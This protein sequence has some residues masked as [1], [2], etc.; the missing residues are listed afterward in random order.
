MDS[1]PKLVV[2]C[3]DMWCGKESGT[4][5]NI[6]ILASFMGIHLNDGEDS[7]D[8]NGF[9]ARYFDGPGL[10]NPV[11]DRIFM[12]SARPDIA[13]RCMDI[14]KYIVDRFTDKHE[15]WMFG[16]GHGAYIIRCVAGM[17]SNCGIAKKASD[18]RETIK[19][20]DH[21]YSTYTTLGHDLRSDSP[22]MAAFGNHSSWEIT[23]PIKYMGILDTTDPM[24]LSSF[25]SMAASKHPP[26]Y[27]LDVLSAVQNVYHGI[28]IHEWLPLS[29]S[30]SISAGTPEK[31]AEA[32]SHVHKIWFP[33]THY[34]LGRQ[35]FPPKFG[36]NI[37]NRL[38]SLLPW[39]LWL[40]VH[41][42]LILSDLVLAWILESILDHGSSGNPIPNIEYQIET[43]TRR[44]T[45]GQQ[46]KG[47]G[48]IWPLI[49][50]IFDLAQVLFPRLW[51][52]LVPYHRKPD[53]SA[54]TYDYKRPLD[55][56][57]ATI[58]RLAAMSEKR[59]PSATYNMFQLYRYHAGK[60]DEAT[61]KCL[62]GAEESV[63][64]ESHRPFPLNISWQCPNFYRSH[65]ADW[66]N[67]LTITKINMDGE[68]YIARTISEFLSEFFGDL[69]APLLEWMSKV[70]AFKTRTANTMVG[71]K[72][73]TISENDISTTLHQ[74]HL[75]LD[76]DSI[77]AYF[78][79]TSIKVTLPTISRTNKPLLL[80]A[81][82]WIV[83][84]FQTPNQ[85][86][87]GLYMTSCEAKYVDS[88]GATILSSHR[89]RFRPGNNKASCWTQLF[90]YA[91]I[92]EM[93]RD[94]H[95]K[96]MDRPE[97]LEI[98]FDQLV[99][100]CRASRP[101][102]TEYGVVLFGFDTALIQLKPFE[103]R[104]WHVVRTQGVLM[105]PNKLLEALKPAYPSNVLGRKP[106]LTSVCDAIQ[107]SLGSSTGTE[108]PKSEQ[109]Q[110]EISSMKR[111]S[112][113]GTANSTNFDYPE[114]KV[115][116]GWCDS[117]TVSIG[118]MA[119][120]LDILD[121]LNSPTTVPMV[122]DPIMALT[123]VST[124]QNFTFSARFGF[125]GNTIGGDFTRGR[126][127]NRIVQATT[128]RHQASIL[129]QQLLRR[130]EETPVILWD[131][132]VQRAWLLPGITALL[133]IS[134]CQCQALDLDFEAPLQYVAPSNNSI[135]PARRC[136]ETNWLRRLVS[137]RYLS[138]GPTDIM[139]GDIVTDTWASME[140]AQA[141]CK[142]TTT[143]RK[144]VKK[145]VV[146]G[147][148]LYD[149][150]TTGNIHLRYLNENQF[151]ANIASW[152]PLAR[153]EELHVIFCRRVGSVIQCANTRCSGTPCGNFCQ[154]IAGTRAILSCLLPDLR[155]YFGHE[156]EKY[157]VSGILPVTPG[158]EWIPTRPEIF[159]HIN[160][161]LPANG[162][163]ECCSELDRLQ[164]IKRH[165]E[166]SWLN[167]VLRRPYLFRRTPVPFRSSTWL[168][169]NYAVRFGSVSTKTLSY[170]KY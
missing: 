43:V 102:F 164:T 59:Y 160:R 132:T 58:W 117:P 123:S 94:L 97:G 91:S 86:E 55:Q 159:T 18:D 15:I 157:S 135:G 145:G 166:P 26:V 73:P 134:I 53:L 153:K 141:V 11:L 87:E 62:I 49:R 57:G 3:D 44:L 90:N 163:C 168:G 56:S 99:D 143:G 77:A 1:P 148:G 139:F 10:G 130:A 110:G 80:S 95:F 6:Y 45:N 111:D 108:K 69:G 149:A 121:C 29:D 46:S 14:Y 161:H 34:D 133:F 51:A 147:Y 79:D 65:D 21:V 158:F 114:G 105:T 70:I 38:V 47:S 63:P 146:F 116:A 33:G 24:S 106:E 35:E 137:N 88:E 127:R 167:A 126:T 151:G 5:T 142:N 152:E 75:H 100:L 9:Q 83:A 12:S 120:N 28:A 84:V 125:L 54:K 162:V 85:E 78:A 37:L 101:W 71:E 40:G 122:T 39:S 42:N 41:P 144:H 138:R 113:A 109:L 150:L 31:R 22:R 131:D 89:E 7:R 20:V 36:C 124:V 96:A 68:Y 60:I 16:L 169:E 82:S 2:L 13:T 52:L 48:G 136:L 170:D 72:L 156:W 74:L 155:K 140:M 4:K 64:L 92:A 128:V 118:A 129:A 27:D 103:S 50:A 165:V 17:I 25:I 76:D 154:N 115:Y 66:S 98:D 81:L 67:F 30:H 32:L 107:S 93:P 112:H 8:D 104:R 19:L 61:Y 119:P 23:S